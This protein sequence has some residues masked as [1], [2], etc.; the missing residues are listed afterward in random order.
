MRAKDNKTGK[1]FF[2]I[3]LMDH[4]SLLE[5]FLIGFLENYQQ[6]DGSIKIPKV[7]KKY[8]NNKEFIKVND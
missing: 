1:I 8:L 3:L 4:Q 5:E 7:L 6:S 2:L